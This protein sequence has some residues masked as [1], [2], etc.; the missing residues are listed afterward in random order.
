[1]YIVDEWLESSVKNYKRSVIRYLQSF[2]FFSLFCGIYFQK[3]LGHFFL[4]K[5]K[6]KEWFF[7]LI[8]VIRE[9]EIFV[10]VVRD[11]LFFRPGNRA[12]DP[13]PPPPCAT[14]FANLSILKG[15]RMQT[16]L[17]FRKTFCVTP[18]F[19]ITQRK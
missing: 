3:L 18:R 8:F 11:S 17:S 7:L 14:L 4:H 6:I 13:L 9:N 2:F 15:Q 5:N 10:F 19:N 12:R 1:M 16:F